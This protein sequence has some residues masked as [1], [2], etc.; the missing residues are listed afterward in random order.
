[1]KYYLSFLFSLLLALNFTACSSDSSSSGND[2]NDT[3]GN[4]SGIVDNG[5]ENPPGIPDEEELTTPNTENG[6]EISGGKDVVENEP[7]ESE[8]VQLIATTPAEDRF[9]KESSELYVKDTATGLLWE[10]AGTNVQQSYEGAEDYCKNLTT[11][12][13]EWRVPTVGELVAIADFSKTEALCGGLRANLGDDTPVLWA[14]DIDP[15]NSENRLRVNFGFGADIGSESAT[16]QNQVICVSGENR[17]LG[18]KDRDLKP[19]DSGELGRY[20]FD[21]DFSLIWEDNSEMKKMNYKEAVQHCAELNI[22]GVTDWRLPNFNELFSTV[23][24]STPIDMSDRETMAEEVITTMMESANSMSE[25]SDMVV[26]AIDEKP[27]LD[28]NMSMGEV[29]TTGNEVVEAINHKKHPLLSDFKHLGS[30]GDIKYWT[31]TIYKGDE[32]RAW[33]VKFADG[34]NYYSKKTEKQYVRCVKNFSEE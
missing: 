31:S 23:D 14:S 20:V 29:T 7:T 19:H 21:N 25:G 9:D 8:R 11:D 1:M 5:G 4:D 30:E 24:L 16:A 22:S 3:N 27:Y 34:R 10:R 26:T 18:K 13:K 12:E 33:T 6:E 15:T 2:D 32:N 17:N 28:S